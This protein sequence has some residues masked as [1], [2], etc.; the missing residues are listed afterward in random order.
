MTSWCPEVFFVHSY[1]VA[2]S[3]YKF[4]ARVERDTHEA[5][6]IV[7][8]N[9]KELWKEAIKKEM[10]KIIE[11]QVFPTTLDGKPPT[12]GH[13]QITCHMIFHIKFGGRKKASVILAGGHR[14]NDLGEEWYS[15]V[16]VP[17]AIQ[18]GV[19]A[20]VYNELTGI[21]ADLVMSTYTSKLLRS[22]IPFLKMTM[23][24]YQQ[25]SWYLTKA[26]MD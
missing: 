14:T 6:A 19:F 11:F 7:K 12:Y 20:A 24:S 22:Y 16:V 25:K 23:G 2:G 18:L 8:K 21:A 1:I 26:C 10:S 15:G 3:V 4:D 5:L 17:E 13:Q 9:K